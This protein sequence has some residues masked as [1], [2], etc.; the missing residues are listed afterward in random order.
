MV[1]AISVAV[2]AG[3]GAI[4]AFPSP[5]DAPIQEYTLGARMW[6]FTSEAAD[7]PE[8]VVN[9]GDIVRITVRAAD[10]AHNFFIDELDVKSETI[11]KGETITVEFVADKAGSFHYYCSLPSHR[12]LGMEGKITVK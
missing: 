1:L 6:N 4:F 2:L 8:I 12:T 7:N 5:V 10:I 11:S 3:V 9:K